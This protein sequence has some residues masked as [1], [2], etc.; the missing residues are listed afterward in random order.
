MRQLTLLARST[1][2]PGS[3]L[4]PVSFGH[5]ARPL[6]LMARSNRSQTSSRRD[7]IV[8]AIRWYLRFN[9]SY[10]DVEELGASDE[11]RG[12]EFVD[13]SM[14]GSIFRAVD[15]S[16]ARMRGVRL[17]DAEI[18][19]DIGG[20]RVNGVDV[21]PLIESELDRRRPERTKAAAN[22]AGRYAG[23]PRDA[24]V[25]VAGHDCTSAARL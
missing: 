14:V 16:S 3:G 22:D 5:G 25:V 7:V 11:L 1:V 21:E 12:A 17:T 4:N 23:S 18:D 20:L 8:V 15:L 9:L 19:G 24:R 2:R 10:R 6:L 13:L